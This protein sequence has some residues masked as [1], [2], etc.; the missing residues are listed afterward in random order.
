MDR[1]RVQWIVP[2]LT[3]CALWLVFTAVAIALGSL[4]AGALPGPV[5]RGAP[6][7]IA[8]WVTGRLV[9][10]PGR[11]L[12]MIAAASLAL[13]SAVA[14][15]SFTLVTRGLSAQQAAG[16][17]GASL[18]IHLFAAAWA[19]LGLHLGDRTTTA[20]RAS[21]PELDDLD[22]EL[23]DELARPRRA[24]PSESP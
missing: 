1:D 6:F 8:G 14:W 19:Y 2:A 22:R 13:V 9:A 3:L 16:L 4:T 20:A 10:V 7:L 23:R 5:M 21:D 24:T 18:L 15:T 11:R 12:K 17:L